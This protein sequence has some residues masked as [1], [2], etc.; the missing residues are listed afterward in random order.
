MIH[1][2]YRMAR[3]ETAFNAK[4]QPGPTAAYTNPAR[5]GPTTRLALKTGELSATALLR[6]SRGTSEGSIDCR[7]GGSN[8]ITVPFIQ[9]RAQISQMRIR[10]AKVSNVNTT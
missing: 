8:A 4:H 2:G 3:N 10:P 5:G 6:S 7:P 1:T 9:A